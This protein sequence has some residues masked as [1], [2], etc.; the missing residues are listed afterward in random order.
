MFSYLFKYLV[1]FA[2][3]ILSSNFVHTTNIYDTLYG[4]FTDT[5]KTYVNAAYYS[6]FYSSTSNYV[7]YSNNVVDLYKKFNSLLPTYYENLFPIGATVMITPCGYNYYS[8]LEAIQNNNAGLV[9]M[10]VVDASDSF[11]FVWSIPVY[12]YKC[13]TLWDLK[14]IC[15]TE[16]EVHRPF[17]ENID[18]SIQIQGTITNG[19]K[20]LDFLDMMI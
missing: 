7:T 10:P 2:F 20:T 16:F 4:N 1:L 11:Y 17:N 13:S 5:E 15:G 14:G 9:D 19:T 12:N 3:F 8:C 6:D 18:A